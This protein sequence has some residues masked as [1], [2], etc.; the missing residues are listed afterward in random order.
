VNANSERPDR[1]DA[2]NAAAKLH[3]QIPN[4]QTNGRRRL[5]IV[6][7]NG[8]SLK[9]FDFSRLAPFD[10]FGMNAAYRYWREIGWHPRFYA[11]LDLVVGL[12]HKVEIAQLIEKSQEN[13]IESFLLRQNLLQELGAL[14]ERE[15]VFCFEELRDAFPIMRSM[16]LTTGS[17]A[18]AWAT[19]LGYEEIVLLGIDC[20]YVEIVPGAV[21]STTDHELEIVEETENPNYFFEGYQRR[22]DKYHVPNVIGDVHLDS[23]RE[24]AAGLTTRGVTVLNANLQSKVDA[25]DFCLFEDVEAGNEI[26]RIDKAETL[27]GNEPSNIRIDMR[28]SRANTGGTNAKISAP[29]ELS[30]YLVFAEKIRTMSA[31]LFRVGQFVMWVGRQIRGRWFLAAAI[32]T[33]TA[34]LFIP[35]IFPPELVG[36]TRPFRS[37]VML[38]VVVG[39]VKL[40]FAFRE[41]KPVLEAPPL[42]ASGRSS[43]AEERLLIYRSKLWSES[44][45]RHDT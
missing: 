14:G 28:D 32:T 24:V 40:L 36:T 2:N 27:G 45:S 37:G 4:S 16:P 41:A 12:S 20:N 34:L 10:V 11:C 39:F 29:V 23:W 31:T 33:L 19:T 22:G 38:V 15:N 3:S 1:S 35:S 42:R 43:N 25:F 30:R 18:A 7:G 6:L 44:P 8:P 13:G 21:S 5:A 17:H 9:N 26:P